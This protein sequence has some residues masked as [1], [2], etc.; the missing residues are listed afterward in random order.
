LT[1]EILKDDSRLAFVVGLE[2]KEHFFDIRIE[3]FYHLPIGR[4][5][6][7]PVASKNDPGI[8]QA[9][10]RNCPAVNI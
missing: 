7:N 9:L 6:P 2:K 1:V 3:T 5:E 8:Y 10:L 4:N